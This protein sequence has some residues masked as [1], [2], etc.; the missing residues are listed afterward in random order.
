MS[1]FLNTHL[2]NLLILFYANFLKLYKTNTK[3]GHNM[4]KGEIKRYILK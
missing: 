2:N 1:L 3:F 4:V